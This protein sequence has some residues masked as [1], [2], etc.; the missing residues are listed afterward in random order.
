MSIP[1]SPQQ[2]Y[3]A[4]IAEQFQEWEQGKSPYLWQRRIDIALPHLPR[5][6]RVLDAGCGDR[7]AIERFRRHR[8]DLTFVGLDLRRVRP[9]S[10]IVRGDCR[11]LPF[12][13]ESFDGV[14]MLAVIEHVPD[15]RA[16]LAEAARVLREGGV[17]LVT[18]PNPLYALPNAI[19]GR[20]GLKYREG[21]DNSLSLDR[22]AAL[23]TGVGLAVERTSGFLLLPFANPLAALERGLGRLPLARRLLLNQFLKARRNG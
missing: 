10:G 1:D 9:G 12:A 4:Q 5:A 8:P 2:S 16:A 14:L 20:L 22:L 13:D 6:G 3:A 21:Y 11:A 7:T 15:Q 23:V 18:T 19:A 17:L